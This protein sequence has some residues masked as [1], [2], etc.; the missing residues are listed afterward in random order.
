MSPTILPGPER[1]RWPA[2]SHQPGTGPQAIRCLPG[3]MAPSL[4]VCVVR[5]P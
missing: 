5:E 2:M 3:V 1:P 4:P